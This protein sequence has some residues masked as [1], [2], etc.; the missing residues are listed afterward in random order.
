MSDAIDVLNTPVT[1]TVNNVP[2]KVRRAALKDLIPAFESDVK[3]EYLANA[4]RIA[5]VIKE[6]DK[7]FKFLMKALKEIPQGMEL[8]ACVEQKMA[9]ID[10]YVK[11]LYAALK[12][13]NK[14]TID[15]V[16]SMAMEN[17]IDCNIIFNFA[18]GSNTEKEGKVEAS[19]KPVTA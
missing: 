8:N 2:Y 1:F 18:L 15:E 6:E 3:E 7:K 13:D 14:I 11:V 4:H 16:R 10:G 12:Q 9:S 19:Q 17:T 5:D